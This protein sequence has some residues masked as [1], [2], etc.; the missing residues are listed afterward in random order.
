MFRCFGF[1]LFNCPRFL[2]YV[3]FSVFKGIIFIYIDTCRHP[4]K[5]SVRPADCI[6]VVVAV[7]AV[8]EL[9]GVGVELL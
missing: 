4:L 7:V 9:Y 2:A 8:A 6:F 5:H 1:R 3:F